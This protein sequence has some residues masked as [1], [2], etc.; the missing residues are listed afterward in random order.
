MATRKWLRGKLLV[1][2]SEELCEQVLSILSASISVFAEYLL[3]AHLNIV[4]ESLLAFGNYL[5]VS[6][7]CLLNL[8]SLNC[9]LLP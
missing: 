1:Q 2:L 8:F 6:F 7:D 9:D 3:R 4:S 5:G